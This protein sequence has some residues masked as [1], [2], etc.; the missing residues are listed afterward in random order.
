[1][2]LPVEG[3]DIMSGPMRNNDVCDCTVPKLEQADA[4]YGPSRWVSLE[5]LV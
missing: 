2:A 1:M 4:E 3:S 5:P